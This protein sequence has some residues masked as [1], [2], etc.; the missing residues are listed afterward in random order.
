M[1]PVYTAFCAGDSQRGIR[2]TLRCALGFIV[3][4]AVV[5]VSTDFFPACAARLL[6]HRRMVNW[7]CGSIV[8]AFGL[9]TLGLFRWNL[10]HGGSRVLDAQNISFFSSALLGLL[11]ASVVTGCAAG[12]Y[13]PFS[14]A[15]KAA[16]ILVL[17]IPHL[18]SAMLIDWL[19]GKF[20][21]A[22]RH[23]E[24]INL[25]SGSILIVFGLLMASG[26]L[27]RVLRHLSQWPH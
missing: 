18:I 9:N 15:G 4:A 27:E 23:S 16:R 14:A 6:R 8:T 7:I 2:K 22:K 19:K 12:C 26:V 3:G 10:L 5:F 21:L 11:L 24:A 25:L 1:F 20:S 13:R 17:G